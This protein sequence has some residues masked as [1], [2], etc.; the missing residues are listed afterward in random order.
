MRNLISYNAS[1]LWNDKLLD[2]NICISNLNTLYVKAKEQDKFYIK[3]D[4][5][6]EV[7]SIIYEIAAYRPYDDLK[8]TFPWL[9]VDSYSAL[10]ILLQMKKTVLIS[11]DLNGYN[12]NHE[13]ETS[14][15]MG[16][17]KNDFVNYVHNLASWTEIH[18]QFVMNYTRKERIE[19]EKYFKKFCVGFLKMDANQIKKR[20]RTGSFK[21]FDRIDIPVEVDGKTVHNQQIHIHFKSGGAL[22]IDGSA[23]HA[24]SK[25]S[26]S[27]ANDLVEIGFIL[28]ENL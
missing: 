5:Y 14:S 2:R 28:P 12:K 6:S 3:A 4:L 20:I 23:K 22:N 27:A 9:T 19:N 26:T 25:I 8:K 15:W 17:C 21:D 13:F 1:F 16:V 10:G 11:D 7:N 18:L 24:F